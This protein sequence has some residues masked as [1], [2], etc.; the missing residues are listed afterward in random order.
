MRRI[1]FCIVAATLTL[2]P[3]YAQTAALERLASQL[4]KVPIVETSTDVPLRL[5]AVT[6]V[7]P[8]NGAVPE[9]VP[10]AATETVLYQYDDNTFEDGLGTT[11]FAI[12]VAQRFRLRDTG[13]IRWLEAC[14]R[15]LP[16][17][18]VA[19][20][21]VVFDIFSDQNGWPGDSIFAQAPELITGGNVAA[22]PVSTCFRLNFT[23]AV[24]SRDVWVAAFFLG[25]DGLRQGGFNGNGKYLSADTGTPRDTKVVG[26]IYQGLFG[27]VTGV[28]PWQTA[29]DT[30]A[31]GIRMA[32]D[33]DTQD[34]DPDPPPRA[35]AE[36]SVVPTNSTTVRVSWSDRSDN[37]DG[38]EVRMRLEGAGWSVA[39]RTSANVEQ[40]RVS[41]LRPGERYQFFVRAF[42]ADGHADS[43]HVVVTMPRPDPDPDPDPPPRAP[44]E[45]SVVPT[46]STTVRVS[47]SDRSDNEDGFEVRMRLEGAGWS[48]AARTSANVEQA[49]VSGLRPGE[50]YQ[51]FVRAFHADGHADSDHVVVTMP[52]PDPD[53]DPDPP[54]RAPTEVSVVPTDSTTVRVSWSDRSDNEDGF[55]VRMRLE[56]AGWSVA[57]RTSANV[58]QAR[59]SGLRPGER[60]QFFVRAF[61]ADGHADSDHVVVTMP[62]PDPDPD[63]DPPPRAPTE[64]SVVPTDSTTV[65]VSWSDRSD[66]EDGF[67]VRMR[68]EGAGWS[69]AA[70]TSANVEQARVSGLR[71]GGRYRFF[72]R[73]FHAD[74]HA[75]SDHV[76]VTMPRPDPDPDPDS[77]PRAPTEVSVVPMDSTTVRVSWSDRSDN[78]DGFQVWKRLEGAGWSMAARAPANIEQARVSGLRPGGRY[79]FFV[80]AVNGGG[81]A[82]SDHVVVTMPRADPDS[83]SP[84]RAPTEVS[85]VPTNGTT[86]RVSWSDRSDNEDGFE[87]WNRFAGAGWSVAARTP[88]NVEQ[89]QVS[90]LRPGGRYR[91]F[92]RAFHADGHANSDH[93]VV[94]M[95]RADPDS[96]SPPRAPTEV[97]VVPTDS[98]TV[99][100]SWS[101]RSDNEDGFQVWN[102]LEGAGWSVAAR[103]SADIEQAHVSGLRL[104]GRYRFFVRA[105]HA[106]GHADSDPVA[107]TMREPG[108]LHDSRFG[109]GF[110][111]E[112]NGSEVTGQEAG[113]SS[114][115]SSDK[116]VLYW[117]FDSRNPEA[118]VKVLDGRSWNEHWWF[119]LA[120]ASDLRSVTRLIHRETGDEWVVLT[121]FGKDVFLDPGASA[122]RLVHCA[123][124]ASRADSTCAVSGYGTT[125]SLRDAW[126]SSGRIPST[127]VLSAPASVHAGQVSAELGGRRFTRAADP[128]GTAGLANGL[129]VPAP[130]PT[131]APTAAAE[132]AT[133]QGSQFRINFSAN[134]NDSTFIGESSWSSDQGVLYWLFDPQNP[135]ALVKVLD[136]RSWNGHWWFDL[137]VASDLYSVTRV[138]H[139]ETGDEWV[140][141]TGFG[142]D[143]F[144]EPGASANRLVH[145][146]FPASRADGG[147]AVSGY[148]TTV[149]LRDAW[150]ST[151]SIPSRHHE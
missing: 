109:V 35:P 45:V 84:P 118:L 25:D 93:V 63:P 147:C 127:Y 144:R 64:V 138:I 42:H 50:R 33:H 139:V 23:L 100:V 34:P 47:W 18:L 62:R 5:S 58:E 72:V 123:F 89:A 57:A 77:P 87:V 10:S 51:F 107:V 80:R 90:G 82:N 141:L 4:A 19:E 39:A 22:P 15:R 111:A 40:A 24:S 105:F 27:Q 78:E 146:A 56:G 101:D 104:G 94:T 130:L 54:P 55:E 32:V 79:R 21:N 125:V 30:G 36:V 137:A 11:G 110:S 75:D 126:D 17:D 122:N 71:P 151:G 121:G 150:D 92:V 26:R 88:A 48:V 49:R 69:V 132:P 38:F 129:P 143:V 131:S 43:D 29:S 37:E 7:P 66:N 148:G 86:V 99:R 106:D 95:P 6:I 85:V 12:Q 120:V 67:E 28:G 20:H 31:V 97:S 1:V 76:A 128:Q 103:T 65:R 135:E 136:G 119:D 140:V 74:G 112:A 60:Y 16:W 14:F 133:L 70:R 96:D 53:P 44:T 142:K 13:R 102:R 46:D 115:W 114:G 8:I 52:R 68:L 41:G 83:D 116:G 98:T 2:E 3:A 73:A 9:H 108:T 59:V 91:F 113:W 145:C 61:H 117:L 134:A 81:H 124:P 149:S